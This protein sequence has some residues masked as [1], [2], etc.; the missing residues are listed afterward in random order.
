MNQSNLPHHFKSGF[1]AVV[2]I[3]LFRAFSGVGFDNIIS[4][5]L[6][7]DISPRAMLNASVVSVGGFMVRL[8]VGGKGAATIAPPSSAPTLF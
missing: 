1:A 3:A 2:D 8:T 4:G 6:R 5:G 7:Y